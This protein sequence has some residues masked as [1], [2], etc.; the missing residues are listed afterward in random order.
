MPPC[1]SSGVGTNAV[2]RSV[3]AT[4]TELVIPAA[5]NFHFILNHYILMELYRS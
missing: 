1:L 3:P 2:N 4:T 5:Q